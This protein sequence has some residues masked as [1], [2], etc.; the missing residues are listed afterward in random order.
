MPRAFYRI[1]KISY[2]NEIQ[3]QCQEPFT[4]L[5]RYHIKMKYN[6]LTR[7]NSG[8]QDIIYEKLLKYY[9]KLFF[10]PSYNTKIFLMH[11]FQHAIFFH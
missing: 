5:Q 4:G 2:M 8:L 7:A 6:I 1:T 10:Y 9:K 3:Y 11:H